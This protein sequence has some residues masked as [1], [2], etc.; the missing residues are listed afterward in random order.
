MEELFV[1]YAI[2]FVLLKGG[3][4]LG[5]SDYRELKEVGHLL[6]EYTTIT[7]MSTTTLLVRILELIF[8]TSRQ[9]YTVSL[10]IGSSILA[11]LL[12]ATP[13]PDK[14]EVD[15]AELCKELVLAGEKIQ[16]GIQFDN[17]ELKIIAAPFEKYLAI[18]AQQFFGAIRIGK[19]KRDK[20]EAL[21][22]N[23]RVLDKLDWSLEDKYLDI[24]NELEKIKKDKDV[25]TDKT[26]EAVNYAEEVITILRSPSITELI[27]YEPD[28]ETEVAQLSF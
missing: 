4:K 8:W 3:Q 27:T 24:L 28:D 18:N 15:A 14:A 25:Y 5:R 9:C 21:L 26:K 1:V 6:Q 7:A 17:P 23:L 11:P 20:V 22:F 2:Y 16:P 19:A 10:Q 12:T 13:A